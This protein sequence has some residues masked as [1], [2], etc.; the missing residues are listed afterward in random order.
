MNASAFEGE[1]R[2]LESVYG[3][4]AYDSDPD[5]SD[6]SPVY[7]HRVQSIEREILRALRRQGVTERLPETRVLDYGCGNGRWLGRWLA[8]GVSGHRLM[9]ADVRPSA[10]EVARRN[11]P[12]VRVE[13]MV[14]GRVPCDDASF[15][16]VSATLVFSSILD[17]AIRSAAAA[18]MRR[19]LRPGGLLVVCDFTFDNPRNADVRAVAPSSLEAV[20]PDLELVSA[21]RVVL[22]PPVARRVVPRSWTAANLLEA[23]LP[24]LRTHAVIAFRLPAG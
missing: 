13:T 4:R 1:A 24:P 22:A 20:L 14:E 7:L 8:W 10:V 16:V 15:D 6:A 17:D 19:L 23:A 11:V 3:G 9:G 21:R 2:R 18:D 12:G 5:Y